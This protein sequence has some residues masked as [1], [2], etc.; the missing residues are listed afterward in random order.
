MKKIFVVMLFAGLLMCVQEGRA[1]QDYDFGD[2]PE[3]VVAYPAAGTI[4]SFPTCVTVT[5]GGWI[6][7]GLGWAYFGPFPVTPGLGWDAEPDGNA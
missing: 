2:A 7:H 3:G 6:Q 4:G 1:Q 5:L